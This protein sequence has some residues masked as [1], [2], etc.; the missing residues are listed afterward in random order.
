MENMKANIGFI[1]LGF[2]LASLMTAQEKKSSKGSKVRQCV[3]PQHKEID[4]CLA[5]SEE[6]CSS[7]SWLQDNILLWAAFGAVICSI[8]PPEVPCMYEAMLALLLAAW[9]TT[10]QHKP[11]HITKV[12]ECVPCDSRL[13]YPRPPGPCRDAPA[14]AVQSAKPISRHGKM[15][16]YETM[17]EALEQDDCRAEIRNA[18]QELYVSH[19]VPAATARV[20]AVIPPVRFQADM[21]CAMLSQ[22]SVEADHNVRNAGFQ[23]IINLFCDGHCK[24]YGIKKGL[25]TFLEET[26]EDLI[27]EF[28]SLPSMLRAELK[29]MLRAIPRLEADNMD[30]LQ[31]GH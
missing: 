28:P 10:P 26:C 2:V 4:S 23:V 29:P 25:R 24:L 5:Q 12:K 9:Q 22:V 21:V 1:G 31:W 13:A 17:W 15:K 6:H 30:Y 20:V 11:C 18:L 27:S 8:M 3:A 14:T 16:P 19:D 7:A